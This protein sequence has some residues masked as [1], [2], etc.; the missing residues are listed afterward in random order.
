MLDGMLQLQGHNLWPLS[1]SAEAAVVS[2]LAAA[3]PVVPQGQVKILET[4][5]ASKALHIK[6]LTAPG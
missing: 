6:T 5:Q 3:M 4:I 2:A 1:D